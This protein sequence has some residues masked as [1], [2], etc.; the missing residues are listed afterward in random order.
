[1]TSPFQ[2]CAGTFAGSSPSRQIAV[3]NPTAAGDTLL[4]LVVVNNTTCTVSSFTDSAGNIYTP[5][6]PYTA[7]TPTL[8]P[9]KS[10][11]AT[12]G[13][14]GGPTAALGTT[15]TVQ[16]NTAA[17]SGNVEIYCADLPGARTVD[18]TAAIA[19][20]TSAAP[21]VSATPAHDNETCV[22]FFAT[23]NAGGAPAVPSGFTSLGSWHN[24]TNPYTTMAYKTLGAGSSGAAQ[25]SSLA[26]AS[27]AW[28]AGMWTFQSVSGASVSLAEQHAD[29]GA[30]LATVRVAEQHA[31]L[32]GG[33][34]AAVRVAEQSAVTTSTSY[35][36]A[37]MGASNG[38]RQWQPRYVRTS[39]GDGT[40]EGVPGGPQP[41]IVQD[42][43]GN[44]ILDQA[45]GTV[46]T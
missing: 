23:A 40:W 21:S 20:G 15:D 19:T 26:I 7:A 18:Q 16:A 25:T 27:A 14:G 42:Q 22:S 41:D 31:D 13:P 24:G 39:G 44:S 35:V 3:A 28:R 11:G 38:S 29:L 4:A 45:N 12:G 37:S 30:S 33:S 34:L 43:A 32:G 2:V 46:L 17:I 1:M 5:G 6:T 9:F 10:P 36:P 8:Y